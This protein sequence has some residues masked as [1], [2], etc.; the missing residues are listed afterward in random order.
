MSIFIFKN[1]FSENDHLDCSKNK[2]QNL[3]KYL[4]LFDLT[5]EWIE[6]LGNSPFQPSIVRPQLLWFDFQ[7]IRYVSFS[8]VLLSFKT[9]NQ[10]NSPQYTHSSTMSIFQ[11]K[12]LIQFIVYL[13]NKGP[14]LLFARCLYFHYL[15]LIETEV[16]MLLF[17]FVIFPQ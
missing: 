17:F 8:K 11:I 4:F 6:F 15:Q 16:Y 3:K 13:T 2:K 14:L 10:T 1:D 5:L 9:T 12:I 7:C